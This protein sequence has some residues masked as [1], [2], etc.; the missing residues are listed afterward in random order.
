MDDAAEAY[1]IATAHG[2]VGVAPPTT[3]TD[4]ASG[5]SLTWSEV[6]LYGDCVLRFVSGDY[7]VGA[8]VRAFVSVWVWWWW[9]FRSLCFDPEGSRVPAVLVTPELQ[10]RR[11]SIHSLQHPPATATPPRPWSFPRACRRAPSSPAT[12]PWKTRPKSPTACSAWT[13]RWATCQS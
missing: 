8:C 4:A 12:S 9:W 10:P 2:G 11:P 3:R 6:Q 7:E 13:M 1:R 5:T